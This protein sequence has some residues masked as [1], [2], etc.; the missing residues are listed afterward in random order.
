MAQTSVSGNITAGKVLE[1][2]ADNDGNFRTLGSGATMTLGRAKF[3]LAMGVAVSV[4]NN[5]AIVTAGETTP[6][7]VEG[8]DK[9]DLL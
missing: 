6:V 5:K 3:S 7:T 2:L 1:M 4:N 8:K 9:Q